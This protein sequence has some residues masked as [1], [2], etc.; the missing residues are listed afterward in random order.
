MTSITHAVRNEDGTVMVIALLIMAILTILGLSAI[1]T[2]N[3]EIQ[4]T[5]NER[6][7][8]RNFY[9]AEA[10]VIAA[11]QQLEESTPSQLANVSNIDWLINTDF[12]AD[13]M[14]YQT[15]AGTWVSLQ[16]VSGDWIDPPAVNGI[17][18][19]VA[20]GDSDYAASRFVVLETTGFIDLTAPSNM[21]SY[22]IYGF[23]DSQGADRGQVVVEI[24]YKRRF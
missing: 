14:Q 4:I 8:K 1:D 7:Y 23:Y 5:S 16:D 10:A 21:H 6:I 22:E 11:A 2:S 9:K 15:P 18:G 19:Q 12:D 13:N 17:V 20:S 24:G 3:V